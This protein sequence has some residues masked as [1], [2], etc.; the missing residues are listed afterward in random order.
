[1]SLDPFHLPPVQ[2]AP[3]CK[4]GVVSHL[5]LFFFQTPPSDW[6]GGARKLERD[7]SSYLCL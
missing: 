7:L 4:P 3:E 6:D 5:P 1:M 2:G